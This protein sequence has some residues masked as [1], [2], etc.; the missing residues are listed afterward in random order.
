MNFQEI[1]EEGRLRD[2]KQS[3][4]AIGSNL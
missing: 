1:F 3:A 4:V 2:S